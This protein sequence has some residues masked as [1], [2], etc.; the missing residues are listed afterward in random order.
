[1][2][3]NDESYE[4]ACER[5]GKPAKPDRR[6]PGDMLP[7]TQCSNATLWALRRAPEPKPV[8]TSEP[9]YDGNG[10]EVW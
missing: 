4:W 2:T 8:D 10:S 9:G 1:M 5:C 6:Y 7:C 3:V